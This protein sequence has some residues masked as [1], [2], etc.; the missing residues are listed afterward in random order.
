[1]YLLDTDIIIWVLRGNKKYEEL[2]Q[3]LK[4]KDTLSISTVTIAEIYKNIF[5]SEIVKTEN[6]L[7]E[8][9][10]WDVTS[11][12]AKQAGLYWQEYVKQL[13]NLNLTDCLIAATANVNNLTLVSLN[14]KH[15][16]MKDIKTLSP[17][18]QNET[19][20]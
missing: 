11:S 6:V 19:T 13:K 2:L 14:T 5:P 4:D 1:M 18:R 12:I 20:G 9:E 8:L 3:N 16:P 15:F 10:T 7:G 17:L